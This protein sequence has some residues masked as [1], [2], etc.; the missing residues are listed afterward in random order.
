MPCRLL[1]T[2]NATAEAATLTELRGAALVETASVAQTIIP[3][4][5]SSVMPEVSLVCGP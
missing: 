4:A 1:T 5:K 2:F 3:L